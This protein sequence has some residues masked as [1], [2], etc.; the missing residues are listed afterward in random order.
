MYYHHFGGFYHPVFF[1]PIDF[2]H[3]IAIGFLALAAVK[4][5]R[6]S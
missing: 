1:I 5:L 6:R 4:V 2:W 3:A